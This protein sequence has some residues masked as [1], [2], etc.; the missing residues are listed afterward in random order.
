MSTTETKTV[1]KGGEFLIK[2]SDSATIFTPEQLNEEQR[3]FAQ[4]TADFI[5][6][7]VLPNLQKIDKQ[8]PGLSVKLLEETA[9][10]GLLGCLL[11]TSRC[12]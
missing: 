12:V 1:L 2:E 4:T 5:N 11:Y 3:M 10:L 6:T 8:E 7:R 9:E